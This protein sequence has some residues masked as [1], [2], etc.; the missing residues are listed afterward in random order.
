MANEGITDVRQCA[1]CRDG[2]HENYDD[3]I[4]LVVVRDPDNRGRYVKRAWLCKLHRSIYENDGYEV[5]G[6]AR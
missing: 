5:T 1:D 2:E 6:G 4:Q 3:D